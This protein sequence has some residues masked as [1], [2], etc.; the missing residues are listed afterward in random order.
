MRKQTTRTATAALLALLL[1]G[2]VWA[3]PPAPTTITV[4][5][6]HCMGCAKKMA[7]QL[8]AVPGVAGV[9]ADVASTTLVITA[10][11][12]QAPSPRALWEAVERAGYRPTRLD[13]PGGSFAAKPQL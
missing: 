12:E 5:D 3:A 13:G 11:G 6:M 4:P 10:K 8:Y 9:Q 1:A 2:G 7:A